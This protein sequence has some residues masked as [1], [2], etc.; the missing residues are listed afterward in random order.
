VID[1]I[2]HIEAVLRAK[3]KFSDGNINVEALKTK[4]NDLIE[5]AGDIPEILSWSERELAN[6][7]MN[8]VLS[9]SSLK[10]KSGREL[11]KELD[12]R[13]AY[14]YGVAIRARSLERQVK[15]SSDII[16]TLLSYM[17]D[18]N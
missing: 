17:K 16:R 12:E 3:T 10:F 9:S 13:C 7:R 8:Y 18:E 15:T 6:A 11:D 5:C 1:R 14:E 2:E 4:A